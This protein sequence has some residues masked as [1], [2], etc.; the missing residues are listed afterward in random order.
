MDGSKAG[1]L[2]KGIVT[3]RQTNPLVP[4]YQ[5][6]GNSTNGAVGNEINN[7]Y[8]NKSRSSSQAIRK[9]NSTLLKDTGASQ[10]SSSSTAQKLDKFIK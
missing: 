7:P 4:A 6:P 10:L 2:Q 8:A 3:I 9:P 1:S 5:L